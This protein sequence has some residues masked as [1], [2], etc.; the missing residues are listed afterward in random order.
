MNHKVLKT[1]ICLS[2]IILVICFIVKAFGGN[3]FDIANESTWLEDHEIYSVIIFSCTSYIMFTV[4]YMAIAEVSH[5]KI[6]IHI[7]LL[8]YFIGISLLKVL[9]LGTEYHIFL[10]ISSNFI[11]P[12]LLILYVANKP[13]IKSIKKMIRIAIAFALNCGFQSISV[14]VRGLP[15]GVV[16]SNMLTQLIMSLDVLIMLVLY[17]LYSLYYKEIGGEK[18]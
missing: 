15:T 8:P 5:F 4:Y 13:K 9:V 10:D 1:S 14:L 17:W 16:V 18:E 11:I 2:W 12:A 3:F 7:V 6:W